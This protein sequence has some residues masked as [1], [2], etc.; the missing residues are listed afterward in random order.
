M[1]LPLALKSYILDLLNSGTTTT[2]GWYI[3]GQEYY[4]PYR[5][6]YYRGGPRPYGTGGGMPNLG[7]GNDSGGGSSEHGSDGDL[8]D[9]SRGM[10]G[11]LTAMSAA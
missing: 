8:G 1:P 6:W 5:G 9:M 4:G 10:A 7:G 11:G 2:P 3:S